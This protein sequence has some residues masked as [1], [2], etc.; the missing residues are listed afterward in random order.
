MIHRHNVSIPLA[1]FDIAK[2]NPKN[3]H[4]TVRSTPL[5]ST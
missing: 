5:L 1:L 4:P 3:E 2:S